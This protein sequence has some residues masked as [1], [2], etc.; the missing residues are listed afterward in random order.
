MVGANRKRKFVYRRMTV[1]I[2]VHCGIAENLWFYAGAKNSK[3]GGNEHR[4]P[5]VQNPWQQSAGH[6]ISYF[7][8]SV[9]SV[10]LVVNIAYVYSAI[11]AISCGALA[12]SVYLNKIDFN[13]IGAP[14]SLCFQLPGS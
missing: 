12:K 13:C 5:S 8:K 14:M 7:H 11:D 2:T 6:E 10:R 3:T 4:D 1:D 9:S